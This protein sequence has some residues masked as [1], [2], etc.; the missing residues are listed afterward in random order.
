QIIEALQPFAVRIDSLTLDPANARI[1]DARNLEAIKASLARFGQRTPLVVQKQGMVVRK[2]N[3]TLM[4]AK[5]LNWQTIA[6]I[7]VDES[8]VAATAYAI[9]DNRTSDLSRNDDP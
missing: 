1:H 8:D 2:G 7:V 5:A 3:G 4:A 9:A 6:A